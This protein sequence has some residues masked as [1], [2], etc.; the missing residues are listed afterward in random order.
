MLK[1]FK[2]AEEGYVRALRIASFTGQP[3]GDELVLQRLGSIY[4]QQGL[5]SEA[6]VVF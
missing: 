4:M 1:R 2:E 5:Y 6:S 3:L